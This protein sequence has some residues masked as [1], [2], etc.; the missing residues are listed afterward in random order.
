M[1]LNRFL[2]KNT[3]INSTGFSQFVWLF[4]ILPSHGFSDSVKKPCDGN[5]NDLTIVP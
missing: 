5:L 1:G 2:I 3:E 4:M